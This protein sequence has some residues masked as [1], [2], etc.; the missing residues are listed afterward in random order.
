MGQKAYG[1]KRR[2]PWILEH[3]CSKGARTRTHAHT[4]QSMFT[5]YNRIRQHNKTLCSSNDDELSN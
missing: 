3:R 2:I 5:L 4:V 1:G